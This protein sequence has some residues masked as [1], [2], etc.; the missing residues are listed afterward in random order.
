M[1]R[2]ELSELIYHGENSGVEFKRDKVRPE[3]LAKDIVALANFRGGYILLGVEDDGTISGLKREPSKVEE[4]VMN[5]CRS[6]VYP[7]IIPY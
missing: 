7:P 1:T 3:N 2:S 5:I 4:W 6:L